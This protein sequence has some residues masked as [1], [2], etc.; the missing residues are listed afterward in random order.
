[1]ASNEASVSN[2]EKKNGLFSTLVSV[3]ILIGASVY[4]LVEIFFSVNQLL[5]ISARP[6]YLIGSHNLIPLLIL[7]PGL[8]LIALGII[9]KQLNRMTPKMY[10]WV[11]K[12]LFYSFIL[13]VLT[14]ILYGGFFVDRYMSNHGYSYCNPLTSVSAL[15]PQ[16]WVSDPGYCLEDSR[17][18]S[19]EVRDWLDTQMAAGE[20][21]TAAEAE[22]QIKQL[23]QDYQKRFN[24]F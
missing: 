17:N 4:I 1:M 3:L 15:S 5:S 19:S 20:R 10:D 9:F 7:I 23:A 8:L 11:F 2:V 16:I 6:L 18:V 14:R 24:R 13:F 22:Q 12:L 21:P